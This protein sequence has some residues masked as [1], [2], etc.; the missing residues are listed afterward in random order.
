[1]RKFKKIISLFLAAATASMCML[2]TTVNASPYNEAENMSSGGP[3]G[4]I[5]VYTCVF[6]ESY[7][8]PSS[9]ITI[10]TYGV[11]GIITNADNI[12]TNWTGGGTLFTSTSSDNISG[13]ATLAS[14]CS[15]SK[16][17][18]GTATN[19]VSYSLYLNTSA[20]AFGTTSYNANGGF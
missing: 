20:S 13:S 19:Y 4:N 10:F 17:V 11:R 6:K 16:S 3:Y 15:V 7:T 5:T 8:P 9:G 12:Y 1:M 14:S 2:G 18:Q